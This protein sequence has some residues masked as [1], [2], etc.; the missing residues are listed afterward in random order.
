MNMIFFRGFRACNG[1]FTTAC[2]PHTGNPTLCVQKE[3]PGLSLILFVIYI[4]VYS[5]RVNTVLCRGQTASVMYL[6]K[7]TQLGT[8]GVI[9]LFAEMCL[10]GV[11]P[12]NI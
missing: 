7:S 3:S 2:S 1:C 8:C 10:Y 11:W 5:V 9:E 12:A 6:L 4:M